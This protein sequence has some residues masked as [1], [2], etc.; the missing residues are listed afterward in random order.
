MRVYGEQG[1]LYFWGWLW[2]SKKWWASKSRKL[3][4][5]QLFFN[6]SCQP[7]HWRCSSWLIYVFVSG[8]FLSFDFSCFFVVVVNALFAQWRSLLPCLTLRF[9]D[10]HNML[11][12]SPFLT[13]AFSS[14]PAFQHTREHLWPDS[15]R[16]IKAA[17]TL[18]PQMLA[19][20]II[21]FA[22]ALFLPFS[23]NYPKYR[24]LYNPNW[25]FQRLMISN[26]LGNLLKWFNKILI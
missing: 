18:P 5:S 8:R 7:K 14:F 2:N 21:R 26:F 6:L 11:F 9:P 25:F 13:N 16:S 24:Y 1:C 23:V 17:P 4:Q 10:L 12:S 3:D 19:G 20:Q 22:L 15:D